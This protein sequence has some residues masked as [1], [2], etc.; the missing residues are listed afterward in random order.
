M[1]QNL[2]PWSIKSILHIK[3]E[4]GFHQKKKRERIASHDGTMCNCILTYMMQVM[5]CKHKQWQLLAA[6]DF[7]RHE[8]WYSSPSVAMTT[9]RHRWPHCAALWQVTYGLQLTMKSDTMEVVLKRH[10]WWLNWDE[11]PHSSK[12]KANLTSALFASFSTDLQKREATAH[13]IITT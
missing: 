13:V 10:H 6:V 7:A 12:K 8:C 11:G 4:H 5:T 3:Q 2:D 1:C 9:F